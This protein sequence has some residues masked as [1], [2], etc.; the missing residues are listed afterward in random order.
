M[1]PDKF[2]DKTNQTISDA[3]M[4]AKEK[5]HIYISP[6]HVASVLFNS[7]DKQSLGFL[8]CK[9]I[10]SAPNSSGKNIDCNKIADELR[11]A[12]NTKIGVQDPP[13]EDLAPNRR[14][15]SVLQAAE[16]I[17]EQLGDSLLAVDHLLI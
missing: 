11:S 5:K 13:V 10:A 7:E 14:L 12:M 16:K 9:K 2:T 6:L 8:V 15:V 17:R 4:L 3:Y 1:N